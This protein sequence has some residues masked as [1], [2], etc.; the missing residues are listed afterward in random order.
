MVLQI[1][2]LLAE[3]K[4]AIQALIT[5]EVQA[6]AALVAADKILQHQVVLLLQLVQVVEVLFHT[7]PAQ[8]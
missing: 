6:V 2:V 5:A 7:S 8:A 4:Q 1:K 3:L